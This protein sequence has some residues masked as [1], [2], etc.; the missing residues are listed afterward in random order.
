MLSMPEPLNP[1]RIK[2][3]AKPL[4]PSDKA[5]AALIKKHGSHTI[6][7]AAD[8]IEDPESVSFPLRPQA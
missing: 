8:N 7:P 1:A 5:L 4:E 2:K 3:A 6:R